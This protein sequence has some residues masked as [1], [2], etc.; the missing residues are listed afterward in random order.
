MAALV[1]IGLRALRK[2]KPPQER[3]LT[4]AFLLHNMIDTSF[5]Y[6]GITALALTA[7]GEPGDRKLRGGV[8]KLLFAL[9]AGLFAYGLYSAVLAGRLG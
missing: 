8:V 7:A 2:K 1:L 4:A 9:Y 6:L 5:F 3:A